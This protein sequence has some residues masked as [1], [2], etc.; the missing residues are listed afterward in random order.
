MGKLML[1]PPI[2]KQEKSQKES[3]PS[4]QPG[5][6]EFEEPHGCTA[7]VAIWVQA[8]QMPK[9]RQCLRRVQ[10]E[11][12]PS[13]LRL[14]IL[15]PDRNSDSMHWVLHFLL[16]SSF[17]GISAN[18]WYAVQAEADLGP[19]EEQSSCHITVELQLIPD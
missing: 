14:R 13:D 16:Q 19:Y 6:E 4:L 2:S 18:A 7:S 17:P 5:K 8:G 3:Q 11:L 12:S 15:S 1:K 10:A 9:E